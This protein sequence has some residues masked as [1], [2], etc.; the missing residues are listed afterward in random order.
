MLRIRSLSLALSLLGAAVL[1]APAQ[2]ADPDV[3]ARQ[4][5]LDSILLDAGSPA[6]RAKKVHLL[7]ELGNA[8]A[9][10]A[11][12]ECLEKLAA[13]K[14]KTEDRHARTKKEYEPFEGF[15]FTDPK[16]W[17]IKKRMRQDLDDQAETMQADSIV[18]LAF[19]TAVTT[20]TE[21]D[22]RK[23]FAR[24]AGLSPWSHARRVLFGGL[25][26]NAIIDPVPLGKKGMKDK[27]PTVRLAVLAALAER[28]APETLSIA[29][30]ALKERGW[31]HRQ[32]AARVLQGI[33]DARG[34]AP[35]V[36][37]MATDEGRML[38]VYSDAL[39]ELTGAEIGAFPDAWRSWYDENKERLA[40]LGAKPAN[41]K[42][43]KKGADDG[44]NYY[45]IETKSRRIVFL[46]DISGSMKEPIG[47][48][49]Q[50]VT[51]QDEE[52]Y[53]G[54]KVDIAKKVLKQAIRNLPENAY[55]NIVVFNHAVKEFE[56][57]LIEAT[58]D[59]KNKAYLMINDLEAS[60]STFTY[61]ALEKAFGMAGRGV[62]DKAYDPGVDTMFVLS[63][64]A[65]T[66]SDI[67]K[68]SPMDP[69][70]VTGAVAEWNQFARI[71]I[72]TI[73]IDPNIGR[74][75]KG[76][77]R[78]MKALAAQNDG[79]YAEIGGDGHRSGGGKD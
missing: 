67:D 2:A 14:A 24:Q 62:T 40:E 68:A 39:R 65:P 48:A 3:E 60:G 47:D 35:L 79:T 17:D 56:P 29:I 9:A 16:A 59:N 61:G 21:E 25:L 5:D 46:I 69:K 36:N 27:D 23:A 32:A 26:R 1:L 72:H 8:D 58:Q 70:K 73:A 43:A 75:G 78:F 49:P 76:F 55:F 50:D 38:E 13:R 77:I 53:S 74:G 28:K 12:I 33:G 15:T 4:A 45:G 51:G 64:G 18:L 37:A 6:Q 63:D 30:K 54:L 11:L 71:V 57:A 42:R 41:P 20:F 44:I 31:P 52:T 66:D 19:T 10:R 22:A 7:A 34:I